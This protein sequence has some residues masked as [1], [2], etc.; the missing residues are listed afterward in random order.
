MS[1]S[2]A[3]KSAAKRDTYHHGDLRRALLEAGRDV[4]AERGVD[5]LSL[6]EVARRA[7][8]SQAAPYHHFADK[9][10]LVS[11]I[12]QGGFDDFASALRAGAEEAGESALARLTAMGLIYVRFAVDQPE[13]FRLMFRPELRQVE[14]GPTADAIEAAGLASY[15]VFRDAVE[16]AIREGSVQ[17]QLDDV[18]LAAWSIAHGLA[19]ILVD[20]PVGLSGRTP[21]ELATVVLLALGAGIASGRMP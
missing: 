2:R 14:P 1:R 8:V 11:A 12:V 4:V 7:H 20:G 18:A 19:T 15:Q 13:V 9:A 3:E 17:G 16:A 6:R 10:E 21:D 5:G